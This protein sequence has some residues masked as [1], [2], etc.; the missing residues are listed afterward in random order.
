MQLSWQETADEKK[1]VKKPALYM[2]LDPKNNLA[3]IVL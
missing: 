1:K 2:L 3:C